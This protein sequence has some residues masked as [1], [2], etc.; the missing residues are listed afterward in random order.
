M[1]INQDLLAY[2]SKKIN[3]YVST[4]TFRFES[5]DLQKTLPTFMYIKKEGDGSKI[6]AVGEEIYTQEDATRLELFRSGEFFDKYPFL[7]MFVRYGISHM[8]KKKAMIRPTIY[9]YGSD[10]LRQV[11]NGYEKGI[12][13][14]V[15]ED[16]GAAFIHMR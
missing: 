7:V 8:T 4:S 14:K 6:I 16:A 13:T 15:F 9:C 10:D 2:F 11:F 1:T 5:G 12:L 3:V